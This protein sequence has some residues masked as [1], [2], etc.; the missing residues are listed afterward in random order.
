MG[1]YMTSDIGALCARLWSGKS[2]PVHNSEGSYWRN[3]DAMKSVR[4]IVG[5]CEQDCLEVF[6]FYPEPGT[7]HERQPD[8]TWKKVWPV[9]PVKV[10]AEIGLCFT[11]KGNEYQM[12]YSA[13]DAIGTALGIPPGETWE[14]ELVAT[15]KNKGA[16]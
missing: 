6:G 7:C 2:A 9:E 13:L 8:G 16:A 12:S 10:T 11:H 14:V 5:L 4:H 3:T 1:L 15:V